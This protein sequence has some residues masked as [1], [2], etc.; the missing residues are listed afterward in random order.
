M[1]TLTLTELCCLIG[2]ALEFNLD[3]SYW[4]KAEINSLSERGG[5][6]YLELVDGQSAKMRATCWA[7]NK[8][9][10]LAYF[11]SETGQTLQAGMTV[12][13][14]VEIQWHAVY[15]LSLSI[16]N[17]DPSFTLGEIARQRQRT[18]NQLEADGLLEAQ[19]QLTLPTLVS[20]IAIISS[21]QA[22]GY[23]DFIHQLDSTPYIINHTLFP[24][25]M[26]GP[27]AERSILEALESI[28]EYENGHFDAIVIIRGG[29]AT[30][31]LSCFDSYTL[32]AVCAQLDI[33]VITGIGHTRD[34]SVLDIVAHL[35]LKTP[36]AVAEFLIHRME[37]Q[38]NRINDLLVR[39]QRTAERQVLLRQHR[40]ELL[41]QR[42]S[43]CNPETIY[44]KGYSLLTKNGVVIRSVKDIKAADLVTAHL[45]DGTVELRVNN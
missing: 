23:E 26:Q 7:G 13:V 5:H 15:G 27:T 22:A 19:K 29:G 17:I 43:A 8:E 2:E 44:K 36:T 4:V 39:L 31:D 38:I 32:C 40:I 20:N 21:A 3:S 6:L 30:S 12:L 14:E 33:P 45:I 1:E 9:V 41:E 11:Q 37:A 34:I 42:L 18:I 25:I 16:I 35:S 10:L 28:Q 24:A